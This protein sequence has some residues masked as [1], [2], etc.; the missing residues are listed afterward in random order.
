MGMA[1][2]FLDGHEKTHVAVSLYSCCGWEVFFFL[3]CLIFILLW[4]FSPLKLSPGVPLTPVRLHTGHQPHSMPTHRMKAGCKMSKN[5][6]FLFINLINGW[7]KKKIQKM[8][9]RLDR[10]RVNKDKRIIF[11]VCTPYPSVYEENVTLILSPRPLLVSEAVTCPSPRVDKRLST[12]FSL[13]V[14]I[15]LVILTHRVDCKATCILFAR[16]NARTTTSTLLVHK[17]VMALEW[18]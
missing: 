14:K 17:H 3:H 8:D 5:T 2:L 13:C 11:V 6:R 9:L 18:S 4:G 1:W 12:K 7:R 15:V 10:M 16:F